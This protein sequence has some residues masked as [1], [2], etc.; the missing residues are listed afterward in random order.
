MALRVAQTPLIL[1]DAITTGHLRVSQ[2][3][4]I[5]EINPQTGQGICPV[6]IYGGA[7]MD[8]LGN[9]ISNGYLTM[10][11]TSDTL[12]C[13]ANGQLVSGKKFRVPLDVNGNIQGTVTVEP[14]DLL[15][16]AGNQ[17]RVYLYA[18]DGTQV[19]ATPHYWTIVSLASINVGTLIPS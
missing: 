16:P 17:Y 10:Q 8:P 3:S 2:A 13:T 7:F 12:I 15:T 11:L 9:P 1:E 6:Q 19:W 4:L 14:N 5:F 18:I